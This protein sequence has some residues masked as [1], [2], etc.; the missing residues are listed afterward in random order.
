MRAVLAHFFDNSWE[1]TKPYKWLS[2]Q[3]V[4]LTINMVF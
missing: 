3:G 2:M 4:T 1:V